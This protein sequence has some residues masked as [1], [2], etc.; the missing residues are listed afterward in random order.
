[1]IF[2]EALC[3]GLL[4]AGLGV[5]LSFAATAALGQ[6]PGLLGVLHPQYSATAF[7]RAL[8]TAGAMSVLG[9]SYPALRAARLSPLAALSHE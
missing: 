1:M 8:Y 9:G 3:I 2:G 5:G 6:L 4:G 7:W